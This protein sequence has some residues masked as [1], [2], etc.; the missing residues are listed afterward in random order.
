MTLG[1]IL[2]VSIFSGLPILSSAPS[3]TL[4]AA[5]QTAP[6]DKPVAADAQDQGRGT[7]SPSTTEPSVPAGTLAKPANQKPPATVKSQH[8]KRVLPRNCDPTATPTPATGASPNQATSAPA[9]SKRS[10]SATA[11]NATPPPAPSNCPPS[12]KIVVQGGTS[13][14]SIQLAG[15]A[16]GAQVT[17]ARQTANQMLESTE[18]N[19][20]RMRDIQL[21][22]GQ[23]DMVRQIR[24]FV[25]QSKDAST[26]G[27]FD[28]ARTLAWKAQL[29]SEELLK[30]HE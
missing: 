16:T 9:D 26:A 1:V 24:Q 6:A 22:S 3:G 21:S 7:S 4:P 5:P 27:E 19:L 10:D 2:L 30:P 28:R 11:V 12:K 18:K 17:D 14:P 23:Q 13:E 15:V 25:D 20:K 8:R 29:L